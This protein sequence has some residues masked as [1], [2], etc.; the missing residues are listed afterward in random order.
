MTLKVDPVSHE[1]AAFL[2]V[3]HEAYKKIKNQKAALLPLHPHLKRPHPT[4]CSFIAV[5]PSNMALGYA[6]ART[7]VYA[8]L[9]STAYTVGVKASDTVVR[10]FQWLV[11]LAVLGLTAFRE[12]HTSH[13]GKFHGIYPSTHLDR[14]DNSF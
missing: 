1:Y 14:R 2:K 4:Y 5:I 13:V 11:S 12:E 7:I 3:L 10:F 6:T 9:V 8:L